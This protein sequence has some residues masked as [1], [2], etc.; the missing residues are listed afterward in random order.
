MA[1]T[2]A[3]AKERVPADALAVMLKATQNLKTAGI[4][5]GV[6]QTGEQAPSF[7][8]KNHLNEDRNLEAMLADGPLV[9]SFYRGG[10]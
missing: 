7:T 5:G 1:E 10:W 2:A 8:L 9:V 3:Q 6:I 4:E